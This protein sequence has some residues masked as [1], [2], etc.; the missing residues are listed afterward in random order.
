MN[1][2]S[3]WD[4]YMAFVLSDELWRSE[5]YIMME[6]AQLAR[7]G[8]FR[9]CGAFG[10]D[11]HNPRAGMRSVAYAANLLASTPGRVVWMFPQGTITPTDRR[12]LGTFAGAAHLAKRAAPVRCV[13]LALR[14]EFGGEQR[15]E[16]LLRFGPAHMVEGRAD[17]RALHHEMDERLEREMN[18]LHDDWISGTTANYQTILTG[19]ASIN[20]M[21]DRVR[22]KNR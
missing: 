11:R 12:P 1:H 14:Y 16:A 2:P 15:P 8:F 10:V 21:W 3:W 19:H 13:P 7:Y 22:G 20:V 5:S 4:G 18:T 17:T 6:E 9:F